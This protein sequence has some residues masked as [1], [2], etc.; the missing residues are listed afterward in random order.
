[1]KICPNCE[2]ENKD[3]YIYC[4]SCHKPL[5][6][7]THLENLMTTGTHELKNRNFRKAITYFDQILQL[8]IG[9]KEAWFLKGIA[10][11]NLGIGTEARDCFRSSGVSYRE[12]TCKDCLGSGNCMSCSQSGICYMCRGRRKCAMCGGT[13]NCSNCDGEGCKVCNNTGKCVRCKGGGEC[14]YCDSSGSCPDCHGRQSCG[15]CGGTGKALT[16][17]VDSVP[18][19]LRKYLKLKQ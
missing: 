6:K 18:K 4:I 15:K 13:G 2:A 3:Q 9:D 19:E 5:P 14:V 16:I 10:M 11:S 17:E 12:S 8:N 7:Q 1:M